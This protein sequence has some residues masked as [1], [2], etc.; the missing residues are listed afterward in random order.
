[1]DWPPGADEFYLDDPGPRAPFQGDIYER[2]PFTKAGQGNSPTDDPAWSARPAHVATLIYP[3]DMVDRDNVT[4]IRSQAIA[5]VYDAAQTGLRLADDWGGTW[6]VCPLPDLIGD[7]RMWVADFRKITTIDRSYLRAEQR[8]RCLSELGWAV[9]RQRLSVAT[10]RALPD[11]DKLLEGGR[12]TWAE[13]KMET[14]WV[15]QGRDRKDF[16]DW[17]DSTEHALPYISRRRALDEGAI[18]LIRND[19]A[20]EL[21]L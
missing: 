1:V 4:L 8:V 11:L 21:G 16:H 12:A 13:S 17:L 5:L 6:S 19:L 10:T 20:S 9:F 15:A 2:I 14:A 18:D 7:G 3:C